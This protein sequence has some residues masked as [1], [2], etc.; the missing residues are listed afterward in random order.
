MAY[1]KEFLTIVEG[2]IYE[3][4]YGR[5]F[6]WNIASLWIPEHIK[7]L[8]IFSKTYIKCYYYFYETFSFFELLVS[9]ISI[10]ENPVSL[11]LFLI[12]L[13]K[14]ESSKKA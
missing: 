4:S 12:N 6:S 14:R 9:K 1:L 8:V 5:E 7:T 10:Y 13:R 3:I 2:F 11:L